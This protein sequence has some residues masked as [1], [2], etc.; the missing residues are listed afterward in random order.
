MDPPEDGTLG[1]L[2]RAVPYEDQAEF[3][4]IRKS[5]FEC[6]SLQPVGLAEQSLQTIPS[7]GISGPLTDDERD[8]EL[9]GIRR[10]DAVART[11]QAAARC[12]SAIE[13]CA[14]CVPP[15]EDHPPGKGMSHRICL[16]ID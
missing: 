4:S 1:I 15:A 13:D 8:E 11:D 14:K 5:G 3:D 12:L 16:G 7:H 2:W 6:P 9:P 10:K